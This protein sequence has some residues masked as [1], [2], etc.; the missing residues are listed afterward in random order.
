[1]SL[2]GTIRRSD[3]GPLGTV[4]D[5]KRHLS[6]AFPGIRFILEKGEPPDLVEFRRNLPLWLRLWPFKQPVRYPHWNGA[7]QGDGHAVEFYVEADEPVRWI[8]APSYGRT[9][10]LDDNVDRLCAATGWIVRYPRF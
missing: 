1:M 9:A 2:T 3:K 6:G 8:R 4:E 10:G 5:V 7:Y